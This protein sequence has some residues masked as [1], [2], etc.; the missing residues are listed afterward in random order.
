LAPGLGPGRYTAVQARTLTAHDHDARAPYP[1]TPVDGS[2]AG[3]KATP[4]P[5]ALQRAGRQAGAAAALRSARLADMPAG[6][7]RHLYR[8]R[9]LPDAWLARFDQALP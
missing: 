2:V 4:A 8:N 9:A 5:P 3:L 7:A 6:P 1:S